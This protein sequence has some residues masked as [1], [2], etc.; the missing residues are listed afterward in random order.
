M[1]MSLLLA[2]ADGV[3]AGVPAHNIL[4]PGLAITQ[5]THQYSLHN[6]TVFRIS[7]VSIIYITNIGIPGYDTLMSRVDNCMSNS[8]TVCPNLK[9]FF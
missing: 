1:Q 5:G 8:T 7:S 9:L 2:V 3:V 4:C 6:V